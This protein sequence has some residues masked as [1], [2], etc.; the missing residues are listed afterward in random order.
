MNEPLTKKKIRP[1]FGNN[2]FPVD[3]V[4]SAVELL[5]DKLKR[6]FKNKNYQTCF[7]ILVDDCFPVFKRQ[8]K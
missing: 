3:D 5:K 8:N 2:C 7:M 1:G 4:H 6:N